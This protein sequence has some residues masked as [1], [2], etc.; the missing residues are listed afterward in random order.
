MAP[1]LVLALAAAHFIAMFTWSNLGVII[2]IEG[3]DALRGAGLPVPA[4]LMGV[5]LLTAAFDLLIGSASAKWA[6]MAPVLVP[7][8]MLLGV[9]PE[10]TTA[11][12]RMGDSSMNMASPLMPYF[13]L[14]LGFCQRWKPD[15][16]VGGLIS[17]MLPYAAAL[18]TVGA[19]LTGAWA[20]LE[21]PTGPGAPAHYSVH[22]PLGR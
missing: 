5:V 3:A 4:L 13:P 17:A 8:L 14:V 2:A 16:G 22:A 15:F 21:L 18:V 1:Y 10:M 6:A 19:L 7:M 11:A 9:S 20:A 12:Y